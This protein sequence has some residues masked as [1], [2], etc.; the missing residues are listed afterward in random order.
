MLG[1]KPHLRTLTPKTLK[2]GAV[3]GS[4]LQELGLVGDLAGGRAPLSL[5]GCVSFF[6]ETK[7]KKTWNVPC[8]LS[9]GR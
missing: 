5:W 4:D 7:K 9:N 2:A 1:F 3:E 6:S 8:G